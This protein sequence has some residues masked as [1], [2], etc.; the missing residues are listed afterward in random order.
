[1][2]RLQSNTKPDPNFGNRAGRYILDPK[3]K[4]IKSHLIKRTTGNSRYP[5]PVI[6]LSEQPLTKYKNIYV[7]DP[8]ANAG[9]SN[10]IGELETTIV[11]LELNDG[12]YYQDN[13]SSIGSDEHLIGVGSVNTNGNDDFMLARLSENVNGTYTRIDFGGQTNSFVQTDINNG[14]DDK[15]TAAVIQIDNG[16]KK[17]LVVGESDGSLAM[18]RYFAE[19]PDAGLIDTSFGVNGIVSKNSTS[20]QSLVT[21]PFVPNVVKTTDDGTLYMCGEEIIGNAHRFALKKFD[22]SGNE[23]AGF[24]AF[25]ELTNVSNVAQDFEILSDGSFLVIGQ[26]GNFETKIRKYN[27]DGTP[28][29]NF[30]TNSYLF[31]E[32]GAV[33]AKLN[34]IIILDDGRVAV[35]GYVDNDAL[36]SLFN[37]DGILDVSFANNGIL[38][39]KFDFDS[40]KLT[41]VQQED[42]NNILISGTSEKDGASSV[43]NAQVLIQD[44]LNINGF[45]KNSFSLYPN[46]ASSSLT[47][48]SE[49][50]IQIQRVIFFDALGKQ[51]KKVDA[52]F[53]DINLEN[54]SNGLYFLK[55]KSVVGEVSKKL[56]IDK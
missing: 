55:I 13:T 30:G 45:N 43:F 29:N 24:Q 21:I 20:K 1:M 50:N 10:I 8:N 53:D 46:P 12:L 42:E 44:A 52:N 34:D 36:V 6:V 18:V 39:T 51:I 11:D 23:D 37:Q 38:K 7:L 40:I 28:D 2:I 48:K 31:L 41:S 3:Y 32:T 16:V 14:S 4:V 15:A 56:V 5:F 9:F 49:N 33:D 54:L 35:V 27:Q 19:G 47:I 22:S 25:D 17:I 26:T